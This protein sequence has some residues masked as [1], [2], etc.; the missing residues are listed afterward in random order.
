MAA[1][2]WIYQQTFKLNSLLPSEF[3][4]DHTHSALDTSTVSQEEFS[5]TPNHRKHILTCT[6]IPLCVIH[7]PESD[8]HA[9]D[10]L[11][12]FLCRPLFGVG[13]VS[14]LTFFD[15]NLLYYS[16]RTQRQEESN[17]IILLS[18]FHSL[19][20]VQSYYFSCFSL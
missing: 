2:S 5:V 13:C 7:L 10:S 18:V 12:I 6:Q 19:Q 8:W 20:S 16:P 9:T 17:S 15:C 14:L 11:G 1:P 4:Q 3:P